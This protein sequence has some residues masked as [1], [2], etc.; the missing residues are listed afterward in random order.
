MGRDR[1][2]AVPLFHT[3]RNPNRETTGNRKAGVARG[4]GRPFIPWQRELAD[5]W[6]E[7]DP[8]TG[9][10]WYDTLVLI[11]LRQIG[12]TT[13]TVVEGTETG[14]FY[15]D[16][17]VRYTAQTKGKAASRL[18]DEF[19]RMISRSP[20]SMF[21]DPAYGRRTGKPG[22]DGTTGEEAIR[23]TTGSKWEVEAL[24]E[25]SG[26]GP[27]LDKGIIDEA[28]A[29][30]DGRV[31]QAM[32]PAMQTIDHAQLIIASAAGTTA[33][34]Y[35]AGKR[36]Q[37]EL[38]FRSLT[39]QFGS[40]G[41]TRSRTCFVQYALPRDMDPD[42]PASWWYCHPGL[43]WLTTE[44]KLAAAWESN[45]ATPEEFQ[46]PYL[47][48]WP[49]A[50]KRAWVIPEG[51]WNDTR[52]NDPDA[53]DWTGAPMWSVDTS[54]ERTVTSIGLAGATPGARCWLEVPRQDAGTD[55]VPSALEALRH[56]F[57][58]RRV[59]LDAA[60]P[61]ASLKPDLEARGFDVVELSSREVNAACGGLYDD[62]TVS[63]VRHGGDPELLAAAKNAVKVKSG[64]T[65]RFGRHKSTE[66]IT[67]LYAVALARQGLIAHGVPDYDVAASV[68]GARRKEDA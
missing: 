47:G 9:N 18:E 39:E 29:H 57:G 30:L 14:L 60:G 26:H 38:R 55:W 53:V 50:K 2:E 24:K 17:L 37:E 15:Q 51:A 48:W 25:D 4:M 21:L 63:N 65:W 22:W 19:H 67:A 59:V 66:D 43:G 12:K 33:S 61:A 7:I 44:A 27:S 68:I 6:G 58:G 56:E 40:L 35:L 1:P 46:R 42:D 64:E 10:Y 13:F 8:A 45:Q 52:E 3:P 32:R 49:E 54:P 36:E 16:A 5:V 62:V 11:G 23:F 34:L 28:F 31:E 20:L 41:P